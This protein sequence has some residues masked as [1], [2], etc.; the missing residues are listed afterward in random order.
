MTGMSRREALSLLAGAAVASRLGVRRAR[1]QPS[2]SKPKYFLQ[3]LLAGGI[4]AIF[5]TDPKSRTEVEAAVDLPYRS[6]DIIAA[7]SSHF[8]PHF[9]PFAPWA[10]RM[11]VVNGV[12]VN[13]ANHTTGIEQFARLKTGT[14]SSMPLLSDIIGTTRT[15]QAVGALDTRWLSSLSM[16][17]NPPWMNERD[18]LFGRMAKMSNDELATA[19]AALLA[20][21]RQISRTTPEGAS[22]ADSFEQAARVYQI[23]GRQ[24]F[25]ENTWSADAVQ[26]RIAVQ[27]QRAA[28]AIR[29]DV[30]RSIFLGFGDVDVHPW[31]THN[32]NSTRQGLAS[33]RVI[34]MIARLFEQLSTIETPGGRLLDDIVI[35]IGSELGRFPRLNS[36]YGKDHLPEAPLVVMGPGVKVGRTYGATGRWMEALPISRRTGEP[37][38]ENGERI[39]LDD[40]GASILHLF[41]FSDPTIVGYSSR[42]LPFLVEST[43]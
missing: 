24:R 43:T 32:Y 5:T 7:G 31:D 16:T 37:T 9:A 2:V 12:F 29:N 42:L 27:L 8:G 36:F 25:V 6:N 14:Q 1:A 21:S 11:A 20:R 30:A 40:L 41:G 15:T 35:V 18:D 34:P 23:F 3:I 38:K 33:G 22:V 28:W 19:S 39:T 26:Q 10:K 4:D 17:I 13:T